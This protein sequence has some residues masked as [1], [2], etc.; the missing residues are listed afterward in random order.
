MIS[1]MTRRALIGGATGIIAAGSMPVFAKS[2]AILRGKGDFRSLRIV[3]NRTG[4]RLSTAYWV[5][6]K[7]IHESIE[8]FSYVLRD[9]RSN[10]AIGIDPRVIDIMSATQQLLETSEP[11]EI[12]SGYR[13]PE[14]NA[15]MR[16]KRRGVARNSYHTRGM[17]VDLTMKTRGVHQIASAAMALKAGGVGKYTRAKFTHLD[18]GPLR[19]WGR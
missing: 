9:W 19:D 7:Y 4:D 2:P 3:N 8:A 6:G 14:T 1:C 15:M 5:E 16:R 12:V 18:C 13:S 10:E 11:I 17:A